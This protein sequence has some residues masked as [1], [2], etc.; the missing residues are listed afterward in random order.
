[1]ATL[2]DPAKPEDSRSPG[3]QADGPLADS[4]VSRK[5]RK[6]AFW[7]AVAAMAA[8]L[9]IASAVVTVEISK[10]LIVRTD[11]YRHRIALLRHRVE[12]LRHEVEIQR[13][14][15]A[16][17]RS[18]MAL[19]ER[20]DSVMLA[21]DLETVRLLPSSADKGVSASV[22]I[23]T[24]A[25]AAVLK[26]AGLAALPGKQVYGAWWM[27][28]GA[29]PAR[30]AEF[31][32]AANGAATVYLKLPPAGATVVACVVTAEPSAGKAAPSGPVRLRG[33]VAARR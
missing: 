21:P 1:M 14:R 3:T 22:A 30:A 10:Q 29:H 11:H 23:S 8:T 33:R 9:A 2:M 24:T 32:T 20:L 31:R 4:S 27:L 17:A 12:R 18:K 16:V 25:G 19:H 13:R 5:P 15:L 7:R 6:A 28:K 26:V